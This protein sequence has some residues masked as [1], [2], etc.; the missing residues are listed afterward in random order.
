[1]AQCG[2]DAGRA[3]QPQEADGEVAQAGQYAGRMLTAGAAAVFVV[4]HVAHVVQ[5]VLDAPMTAVEVEQTL[6]VG[7]LRRQAGNEVGVLDAFWPATRGAD[8][9]LDAGD[10]AQVREFHVRMSGQRR[11]GADAP[12]LDAAMRFVDRLV[13]R[14]EGPPDGGSRCLA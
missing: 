13:L 10:L 3:E 1:M 6:G 2:F 12:H 5:A 7:V 14:G 8:A 4:R 11:A 9:A